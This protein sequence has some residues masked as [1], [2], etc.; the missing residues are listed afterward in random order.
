[1]NCY[2]CQRLLMGNDN[3]WFDFSGVLDVGECLGWP[4][5]IIWPGKPETSGWPQWPEDIMTCGEC[6]QEVVD[7]ITGFNL[8]DPLYATYT[9]GHGSDNFSYK[10]IEVTVGPR[11]KGP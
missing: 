4:P 8:F 5:E 9:G 3:Y 7:M 2:R 1:M 11:K 10:K 6:S